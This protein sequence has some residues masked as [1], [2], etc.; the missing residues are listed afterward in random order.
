[1][2]VV[3]RVLYIY[4]IE[5]KGNIV[6]ELHYLYHAYNTCVFFWWNTMTFIVESQLELVHNITWNA[7]SPINLGST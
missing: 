3:L 5:Y 1:M 4:D 7:K 6:L 2:Q